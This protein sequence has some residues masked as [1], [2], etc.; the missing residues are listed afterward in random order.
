M[1]PSSCSATFATSSMAAA[2]IACRARQSTTSTAR[3]MPCGRNG[4]GSTAIS[5]RAS[6]RKVSWRSC[7]SRFVFGHGPSGYHPTTPA[8][9]RQKDTTGHSLRRHGVH[10]AQ[11]RHAVTTEKYRALAAPVGRHIPLTWCSVPAALGARGAHKTASPVAMAAASER[12]LKIRN[13]AG[14]QLPRRHTVTVKLKRKSLIPA[15]RQQTAVPRDLA[16][17]ASRATV[18]VSRYGVIPSRLFAGLPTGP[19]RCVTDLTA[20]LFIRDGLE[21]SPSTRH[22]SYISRSHRSR[23]LPPFC[24]TDSNSSSVTSMMRSGGMATCRPV[25][26]YQ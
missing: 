17:S 4:V 1:R 25:I 8:N 18:G 23:R 22:A 3:T 26:R 14:P 24:R 6:Y 11:R 19:V 16:R 21:T 2:P 5:S 15:P 9:R 13:R 7:W 20:R 10:T 12:N